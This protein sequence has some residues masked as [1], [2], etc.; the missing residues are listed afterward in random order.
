M[1]LRKIETTASPEGNDVGVALKKILLL[2]EESTR[3]G[4]Q[5]TEDLSKVVMGSFSELQEALKGANKM[6]E[7]AKS[8]PMAFT[9]SLFVPI[10][11]AVEPWLQRK[12][13]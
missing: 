11:E 2:A 3:D 4:F 12:Q 5:A 7:E 6:G 10:T 1:E 13:Q 9:R 8:N